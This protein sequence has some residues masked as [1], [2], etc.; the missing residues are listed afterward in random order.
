MPL[1]LPADRSMADWQSSRV[2]KKK[3]SLQT[4]RK[5]T[6]SRDR[7]YAMSLLPWS[8]VGFISFFVVL[9]FSRAPQNFLLVY[10]YSH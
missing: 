5:S 6:F 3:P 4:T 9:L 2:A 8:L 7:S 1:P 10:F